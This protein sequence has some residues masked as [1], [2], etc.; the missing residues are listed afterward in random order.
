MGDLQEYDRVPLV[1]MREQIMTQLKLNYAH[2]NID[3]TEFE[4][5]IEVVHAAV[6]KLQL[7]EIVRDLP[8]FD[9]E[10]QKPE[11][12]SLVKINR[13]RVQ[14]TDTMV[15]ILSG[16]DRKGVWRPAKKTNA[17]T[18]M[19]GLELDFREA[20][21]PP[22]ETEISLVAIMGGCDIIVPPDLNVEVRSL[23]IL[24]G[25]DNHARGNSGL[26]G[27]TLRINAFVLM[28]GVDIKVKER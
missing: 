27:P 20:E 28:G 1:E 7:L 15:A 22:G 9:D 25:V 23:P 16:S 21:M 12:T 17:I 26:D 14:E 11:E 10:T 6:S 19:G 2:D 4:R 24:G 3:E 13:G 18:L 8:K 5:R